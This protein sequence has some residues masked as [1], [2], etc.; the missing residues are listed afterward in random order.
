MKFENNFA[1][2]PHFYW[3][4]SIPPLHPEYVTIKNH[5]YRSLTQRPLKSSLAPKETLGF[6]GESLN[7][8]GPYSKSEYS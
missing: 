6:F 3:V 8:F 5:N 4:R 1:V 7:I 2:E